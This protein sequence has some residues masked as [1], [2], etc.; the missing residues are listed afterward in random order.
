M[1]LLSSPFVVVVVFR[2]ATESRGRDDAAG[3]RMAVV[4][5]MR[6]RVQRVGRMV[7][8]WVTLRR[9]RR[10]VEASR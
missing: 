2:D 1:G 8:R 4:M 6:V 10:A 7:G 5:G 3:M 9:R